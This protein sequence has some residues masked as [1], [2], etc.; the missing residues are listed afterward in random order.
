MTRRRASGFSLVEVVLSSSMLLIGITAVVVTVNI[1]LV[2]HEHQRKVARAL[3]IAE[4]RTESLL[5]LFEG[6]LDLADGKHPTVGFEGF[7]EAGRPG[8]NAFRVTY[9]V[10]PGEA[11]KIG[12]GLDITV[13]WDERIGERSLTLSTVR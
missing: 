7:T 8:G 11:P 6:S 1:A 12:T 5:L 3:I 2:L 9:V 10:T 4:K 13:A